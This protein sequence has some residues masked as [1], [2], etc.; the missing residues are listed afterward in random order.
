[1]EIK[2][3]SFENGRKIIEQIRREEYLI[4]VELSLEA[5]KGAKD[6]RVR[7]CLFDIARSPLA[8]PLAEGFQPL[9]PR[10][11]WQINNA[12]HYFCFYFCFY[13]CSLFLLL[14]CYFLPLM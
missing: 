9:A 6:I 1:M 7:H 10:R 3:W 4:G 12:W 13:F 5:D 11:I 14:F 2:R 8:Q